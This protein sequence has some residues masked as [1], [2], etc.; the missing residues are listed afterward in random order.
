MF[1]EKTCQFTILHPAK[2]AFM[3]E[4]PTKT[5][6]D[7]PQLTEFTIETATEANSGKLFWTGGKWFQVRGL[8]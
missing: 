5:F 4:D 6:T 8:R 3:N 2:L 1:S 7:K